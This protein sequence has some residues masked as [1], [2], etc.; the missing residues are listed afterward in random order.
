[1][2]KS[3]QGMIRRYFHYNK[4]VH[5][6]ELPLFSE[7]SGKKEII[8]MRNSQCLKPTCLYDIEEVC[9]RYA[10]SNYSTYLNFICVSCRKLIDIYNFYRDEEF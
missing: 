6:L 5:N 10:R 4:G 1:M 7:S 3:K 8:P 9:T 2:K